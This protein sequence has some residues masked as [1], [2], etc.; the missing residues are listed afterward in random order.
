[1]EFSSKLLIWWLYGK[2]D[3]PSCEKESA[4]LED[5]EESIADWNAHVERERAFH[6]LP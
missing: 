5:R 2:K 4:F 6:G 3:C 1:M